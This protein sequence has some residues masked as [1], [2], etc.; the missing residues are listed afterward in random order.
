MV[1]ALLKNQIVQLLTHCQARMP[2]PVS[3]KDCCCA[4][5]TYRLVF[6]VWINAQL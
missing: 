4:S 6:K 1:L 5:Q 2:K 3:I